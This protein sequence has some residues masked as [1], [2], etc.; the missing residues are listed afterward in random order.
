MVSHEGIRLIQ[1]PWI[2]GR[3][4]H[5][6]WELITPS[7]FQYSDFADITHIWFSHEHP[8][9]FSPPNLRKIPAEIRRNIT[10]LFQKTR[11]RKVVKFCES[12]GFKDVIE[13]DKNWYSLKPGFDLLNVPHTD[14]D[15]WLCIKTD[16]C[17][18]LNVNDCG[19]ED[20]NQIR[21]IQRQMGQNDIDIL[22]TQFSYANR[23]GNIDERHL[24]EAQAVSKVKEIHRQI[25]LLKP[26]Y[27][28][29][30]ASFVWFCHEENYY[31]NDAINTVDQIYNTFKDNSTTC[32]VILYPG[33]RWTYL[34]NHDSEI[35]TKNWVRDYK[36]VL[37]QKNTFSAKTT[38]EENLIPVG[39]EF[40]KK[41]KDANS[42]FL[43]YFLRPTYI[44][45]T[46]LNRCF[47]LSWKG[48][49]KHE[50]GSGKADISMSS[51]ALQ[52]CF[53]FLWGGSTTRING[54]YQTPSGGKF[55]N[56]KMYF[57]IAELNNHGEKFGLKYIL[58]NGIEKV[59]SRISV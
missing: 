52:Y 49:E 4:F 18:L 59:K 10:V 29:P 50:I 44:Y 23:A 42:V 12:L 19:L 2:D 24:R 38:D 46:D 14:G 11:D 25:S 7:A 57:Q 17:T 39:Q 35:S 41:L 37:N 8:D 47:I 13:L 45:V 43:K 54:R 26:R 6:G 9:H 15:S 56:W 30:F 21:E 32:P 40:I 16:S 48:F 27:I 3:A 1:D 20:D 51:D 5:D 36:S 53:R 58:Q 33:D 31:M 28:I 22:F 34:Q 55:Y